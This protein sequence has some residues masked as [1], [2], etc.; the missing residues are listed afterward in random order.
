MIELKAKFEIYIGYNWLNVFPRSVSVIAYNLEV[1]HCGF[2]IST[3]STRQVPIFTHIQ[4]DDS[5]CL[6]EVLCGISAPNNF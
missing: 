6:S 5:D 1:W 2:N 4:H 3:L